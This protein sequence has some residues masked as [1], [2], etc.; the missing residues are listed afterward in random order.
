MCVLTAHSPVENVC[1]VKKLAHTPP[2]ALGKNPHRFKGGDDVARHNLVVVKECLLV[3]SCW[4]LV[5]SEVAFGTLEIAWAVRVKTKSRV[6]AVYSDTF[7]QTQQP[8]V[9]LV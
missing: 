8:N 3:Q 1:Q 7:V 2:A 4:N 5:H 6:F 9:C